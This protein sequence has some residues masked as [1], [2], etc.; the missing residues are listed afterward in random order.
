[1]LTA[2]IS[3]AAAASA[4]AAR[5]AAL[6]RHP[7]QPGYRLQHSHTP[8]LRDCWAMNQA[9]RLYNTPTMRSHASKAHIQAPMT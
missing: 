6:Q 8:L 9:G 5:V 1:M 7:A 2:D 3:T 4:C